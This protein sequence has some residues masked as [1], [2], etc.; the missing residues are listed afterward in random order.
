MSDATTA[1]GGAGD[2]VRAQRGLPEDVA[3][4]SAVVQVRTAAVAALRAHA[5]VAYAAL[6]ENEGRSGVEKAIRLLF[7][8]PATS[9]TV[10]RALCLLYLAQTE[11]DEA[12]TVAGLV[13]AAPGLPTGSYHLHGGYGLRVLSTLTGDEYT[14]IWPVPL[15]HRAI[16]VR[17]EPGDQGTEVFER[18]HFRSAFLDAVRAAYPMV[19][20][21]LGQ[22]RPERILFGYDNVRLVAVVCEVRP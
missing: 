11:P 20:W 15:P 7:D 13:L 22:R 18:V 12:M 8:K 16:A 14:W 6:I 17:G 21:A 1:P 10:L 2:G 3:A 4:K 9:L 5:L 19:K